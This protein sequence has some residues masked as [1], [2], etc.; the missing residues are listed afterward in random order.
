MPP[1]QGVLQRQNGAGQTGR[2]KGV[3]RGSVIS[4]SFQESAFETH[5]SGRLCVWLCRRVQAC[6]RE[7]AAPAPT[8]WPVRGRERQSRRSDVPYKTGTGCG[9]HFERQAD[10]CQE[11]HLALGRAVAEVT[12]LT[13][14]TLQ[15]RAHSPE[16]LCSSFVDLTARASSSPCLAGLDRTIGRAPRRQ[17]RAS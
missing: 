6:A 10:A 12:P 14:A 7:S 2:T 11:P 16:A 15:S 3:E 13:F 1:S 5:A 4:S 8:G 17:D 9:G